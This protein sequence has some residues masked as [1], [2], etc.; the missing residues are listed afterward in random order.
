MRRTVISIVAAVALTIFA[1]YAAAQGGASFSV[2]FYECQTSSVGGSTNSTGGYT[3]G[4]ANSTG[5]YCEGGIGSSGYSDCG[6]TLGGGGYTEGGVGSGGGFV[7]GGTAS[8][9]G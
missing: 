6:S 4:G 5:G 2:G 1:F 3:D 8:T 7:P 9:G